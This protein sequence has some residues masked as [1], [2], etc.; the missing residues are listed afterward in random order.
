MSDR[1]PA[2]AAE[3]RRIIGPAEDDLV[4]RIVATGATEAEVLEAFTWTASDDVLGS[5]LERAPRGVVAAIC[6]LLA[7]DEELPEE[8]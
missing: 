5:E 3:I 8:R 1:K 7:A 2:T 4:A 6:D